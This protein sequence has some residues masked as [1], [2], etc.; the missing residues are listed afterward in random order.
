[1]TEYYT[2]SKAEVELLIQKDEEFISSLQAYLQ[3]IVE[4]MPLRYKRVLYQ[5][6][7]RLIKNT[8]IMVYYMN[9]LVKKNPTLSEAYISLK[10][11]REKNLLHMIYLLFLNSNMYS[12]AKM[13]YPNLVKRL[14]TLIRITFNL[15]DL[16]LFERFS[17]SDYTNTYPTMND[18]FKLIGKLMILKLCFVETFNHFIKPKI[19]PNHEMQKPTHEIIY[20]NQECLLCYNED[21]INPSIAN[22]GHI[23]CYE[24][25]IK[26]TSKSLNCP[27]CRS[28]THPREVILLRN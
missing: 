11:S 19:F 28:P 26:W 21:I 1:M 16:K 15:F 22:C 17:T 12:K 6:N 14:K 23:F 7:K 9:N 3:G 2:A 24:C 8:A 13:I 4:Y 10:P 27:L 18:P 20:K 25:F 5:N